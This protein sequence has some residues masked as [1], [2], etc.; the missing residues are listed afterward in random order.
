M[1]SPGVLSYQMYLIDRHLGF[2]KRDI[3]LIICSVTL[4]YQEDSCHFLSCSLFHGDVQAINAKKILM[5]F[6]SSTTDLLLRGRMWGTFYG[7]S[8]YLQK[9]LVTC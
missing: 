1:E 6:N 7:H 8:A 3:L 4:G 2:S 9:T 5:S